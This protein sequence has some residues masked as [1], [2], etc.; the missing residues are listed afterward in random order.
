MKN[1]GVLRPLEFM[2]KHC[3]SRLPEDNG[4]CRACQ[5]VVSVNQVR[6]QRKIEL[7]DAAISLVVLLSV[8]GA[9]ILLLLLV[10]KL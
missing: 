10:V 3:L 8:I 5:N 4:L 9:V 6:K 2:C 7:I 1:L